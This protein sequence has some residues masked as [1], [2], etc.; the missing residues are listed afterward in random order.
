MRGTLPMETLIRVGVAPKDVDVLR[1]L[2]QMVGDAGF[3]ADLGNGHLYIRG[4]QDFEPMRELALAAGGYAVVLAAPVEQRGNLDVWGYKPDTLDLMRTL[5][6][7]WDP[8]GLLNPD[9]FLV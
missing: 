3:F 1:R 5:K 9:A 7:R 2:A 6:A 4:V 8:A